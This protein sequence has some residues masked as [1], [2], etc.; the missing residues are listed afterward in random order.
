MAT[1]TDEIIPVSRVSRDG[2]GY[3]VR[4]PHC[5]AVI[6]IEGDDLQEIVG[7][8]YRHRACGGWLSVAFDARYV[9]AV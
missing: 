5:K 2:D 8:Q 4:C 6:G 7:E 3:C 1:S 9:K